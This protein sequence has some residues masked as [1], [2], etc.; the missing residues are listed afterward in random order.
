MYFRREI[1]NLCLVWVFF[2]YWIVYEAKKMLVFLLFRT[3]KRLNR[4]SCFDQIFTKILLGLMLTCL[5]SHWYMY[6]TKE[7]VKL[8]NSMITQKNLF[9]ISFLHFC[10]LSFII[11]FHIFSAD[12]LKRKEQKATIELFFLAFTII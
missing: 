6:I 8:L 1:K 12:R 9:F 10:S 4:K 5:R 11:S 3:L 2:N 7:F